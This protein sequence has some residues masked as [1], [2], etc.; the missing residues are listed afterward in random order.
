MGQYYKATIK[1]QKT[2]HW[3]SYNTWSFNEG[4]KLVEHSYVN[5]PY[6]LYVK[7]QLLREDLRVVW[8]G[9]YADDEKGAEHNLYELARLQSVNV[10]DAMQQVREDI[11]RMKY[12]VNHTKKVCIEYASIEEDEEGYRLDPL[13]IFTAEG[14]G[15]G[16]G[17][18][19]GDN[20]ALVGTWA[21]DL[22]SVEEN[23]P[24]GYEQIKSPFKINY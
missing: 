11:Q 15:R 18:Y 1:R 13:P 17:D 2:R 21:R 24:K 5:N 20:I 10:G 22:I 8:A 23:A 16:G 19:R 6:V 7:S 3:E 12:L 9:D 14:N 4:A